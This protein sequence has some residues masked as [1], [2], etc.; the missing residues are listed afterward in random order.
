MK[1][2]HGNIGQLNFKYS[3]FNF[4]NYSP[5]EKI[6]FIAC[7]GIAILELITLFIK[8]PYLWGLN[9]ISFLNIAAQIFFITLLCLIFLPFMQKRIF[10]FTVKIIEMKNKFHVNPYL[11][12]GGVITV[13]AVCFCLFR[14]SIHLYDDGYQN[15]KIIHEGAFQGSWLERSSP[16]TLKIINS[17]YQLMISLKITDTVKGWISVEPV[18]I[19]ISIL[20]GIIFIVFS[21]F[22]ALKIGRNELERIIISAF[23]LF[24]GSILLFFG[25]VET[26]P[27]QYAFLAI[28]LYFSIKYL[29]NEVPLV[30]PLSVFI[31]SYFLHFGSNILILS[32]V[33]LFMVEITKK[34]GIR[35]LIIG[36]LAA[37]V[38][39]SL[40]FFI[41]G[42]SLEKLFNSYGFGSSILVPFNNADG[43]YSYNMFSHFHFIDFFNHNVLLNP[44]S[45]F[46]IIYFL[47]FYFKKLNW[48]DP[49]FIFLL[50]CTISSLGFEF[51]FR[52]A[53]GMSNS[54]NVSAPFGIFLILLSGYLVITNIKF[55]TNNFSLITVLAGVLIFHSMTW[56]GVNYSP[57]A[58][59]EKSKTNLNMNLVTLSSI[60]G[61]YGHLVTYNYSQNNVEDAFRNSFEE[62]EKLPDDFHP[63]LQLYDCYSHKKEVNKAVEI[64]EQAK[65]KNISNIRINALLASNY[66]KQRNYE[67]AIMNSKEVLEMDSKNM[68]MYYNIGMSFMNSGKPDSAIDYFKVNYAS[69][70]NDPEV[71]ENLGLC[72]FKMT[73]YDNA[74]LYYEKM[75]QLKPEHYPAYYN[76]GISYGNKNNNERMLFYSKKYLQYAP[77]NNIWEN[78]NKKV[79]E[80]EN[81]KK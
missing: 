65:K 18:Y 11:V 25:H 51:T 21:F 48:R 71:L 37:G 9:S 1:K 40:M 68:T 13:S 36:I 10:I 49:V 23:L 6:L 53:F 33:F 73:D 50:I 15:L 60:R 30:F 26:Y 34:Q 22:I 58:V 29:K 56:I 27:L 39:I 79:I 55:N 2:E 77:K 31:I 75:I 46:I 62:L 63:Y 19:I 42:Y 61:V 4:K 5:P 44:L 81:N 70:P 12:W 64:L 57:A 43:T 78:V 7:A 45:L 76:L 41:T 3:K 32:V 47:I 14:E 28:Y 67:K 20:A 8:S 74:I 80:L 52:Y 59:T 35:K 54:W 17:L 16:L 66:F 24:N 72:Y 69:E 38:I